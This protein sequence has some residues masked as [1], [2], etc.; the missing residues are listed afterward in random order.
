MHLEPC[1]EGRGVVILQLDTFSAEDPL[2]SRWEGIIAFGLYAVYRI[3]SHCSLIE[4]EITVME[5][6]AMAMGAMT[7]CSRPSMAVGMATTL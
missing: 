2:Y 6:S 1:T 5:L 4:F 7:G 3:S